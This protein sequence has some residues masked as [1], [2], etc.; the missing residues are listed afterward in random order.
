LYHIILPKTLIKIRGFKIRH[1]RTLPLISVGSD[2][3]ILPTKNETSEK[4]IQILFRPENCI[5]GTFVI[6]RIKFIPL[7]LILSR[8][9][10]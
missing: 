3:C 2:L 1:L 7:K 9:L 10:S 6:R 4:I 8:I 5:L